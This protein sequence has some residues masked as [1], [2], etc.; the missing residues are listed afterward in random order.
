MAEQDS[1]I[2]VCTQDNR[3]Q[4]HARNNGLKLAEGEFVYFC[5]ADDY[6]TETALYELYKKAIKDRADVVN[7]DIEPF[8]DGSKELKSVYDNYCRYYKRNRI[9]K[10]IL[11]GKQFLF[12]SIYNKDYLVSP[13]IKL[14]KRKFLTN[15]NIKFM[16]RVIYEDNEFNLQLM[17]KAKRVSYLHEICYKRRVRANSTV[18]SDKKFFHVYSCSK[19]VKKMQQLMEKECVDDETKKISFLIRTLTNDA[20]R[21]YGNLSLEEKCKLMSLSDEDRKLVIEI[22]NGYYF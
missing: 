11:T 21:Y 20:I 7:F 2:T 10:N 18:T 22:L 5:D 3:G 1:R 17:L 15:N 19:V 14:I 6:I 4:G 8:Y 9:Y 13:C 12:E 16:D